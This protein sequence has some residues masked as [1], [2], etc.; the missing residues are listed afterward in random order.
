MR[1]VARL[2]GR[3]MTGRD[4]RPSPAR[5]GSAR[6]GSAPLGSAWVGHLGPALRPALAGCLALGAAGCGFIAKDGP[7]GLSVRSTAS[8]TVRD[9]VGPVGYAVV[10]LSPVAMRIANELTLARNPTFAGLFTSSRNTDVRIGVGD[11]VSITIFEATSG[12]LFIP[13]EAGSRAGN[14]VQIPNEQVDNSGTITVPYAGAVKVAGLTARQ[15]SEEISRRLSR[16]AIEPQTVVTMSER[17]GND[18]S[19]LGDVNL[20]TRF[21]L[22]P[23]GIKLLGAM[24]R[25]GGPKNPPYETIVT[26]QRGG[27]TTQASLSTIVRTPKQNVQLAPGDVVYVSREPKI[28]LALGATP[29]PG[30]VGGT[31]NRRFTFD[32]DNMTLSEAAA[33]AGGL[34][35]TRADPRGV[36]LYRQET[37]AALAA[38]GVNVSRYREDSVPTIYVADFSRGDTFFLANSLYLR[39]RDVVFVSEAPSADLEKFTT[40]L[41]GLT[42]NAAS[43][44]A[45]R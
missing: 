45:I 30:A 21:S 26:I 34:D 8:V 37:K 11:I 22:D 44:G 27:R 39:D 18:I 12:G 15:A 20:P 29:S 16:R 14:F 38:M 41:G 36:F 10:E 25:A 42:G 43:L 17:R 3:R 28:F 23:G 2:C 4:R 1:F 33:K 5:L 40:A 6:L 19:V 31:N 9:T 35:T 13:Q 7:T 32:N 24:A